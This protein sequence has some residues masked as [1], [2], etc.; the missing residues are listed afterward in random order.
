MQSAANASTVNLGYRL[1]RVIAS[2]QAKVE[3]VMQS[4]V[5]RFYGTHF[6]F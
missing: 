6:G 5:S 3:M 4:P 2:D 1:L